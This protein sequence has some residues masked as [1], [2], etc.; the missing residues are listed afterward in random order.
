MFQCRGNYGHVLKGATIK[1]KN[2]LPIGS[3]FF[4]LKVAPMRIVIITLKDIEFRI[5]L[6]LCQYVSLLKSPN[7]DATNIKCFTALKSN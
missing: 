5:E 7:F 4:P 3:I 2:M 1:G 6:K